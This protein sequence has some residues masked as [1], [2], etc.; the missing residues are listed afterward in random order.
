[1]NLEP[2]NRI[3][4][5]FP[6]GSIVYHRATGKMGIVTEYRIDGQCSVGITVA[7]DHDSNSMTCYPYELTGTKPSREDGDEW[8]DQSSFK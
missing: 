2:L 3:I 4:S 7:F 1:M 5:E 6:P 8:K